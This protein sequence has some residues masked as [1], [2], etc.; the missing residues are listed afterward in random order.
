VLAGIGEDGEMRR[1]N[2]D[3]GFVM[4]GARWQSEEQRQ[5]SQNGKEANGSRSAHDE[6]DVT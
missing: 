5:E 2:F 6:F 4:I 3:P 1:A